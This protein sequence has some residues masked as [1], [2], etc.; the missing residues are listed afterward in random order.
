MMCPREPASPFLHQAASCCQLTSACES[1][2]LVLAGQL[3]SA[4]LVLVLNCFSTLLAV[5]ETPL[6]SSMLLLTIRFFL[7]TMQ[8]EMQ[9]CWLYACKL[10]VL[11]SFPLDKWCVRGGWYALFSVL[12][13]ALLLATWGV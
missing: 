8:K 3:C 13:S 9:I 1:R 6:N 5:W 10:C 12:L 11:L 4:G 2:A 7:V